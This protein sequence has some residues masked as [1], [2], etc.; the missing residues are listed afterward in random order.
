MGKRILYSETFSG[1]KPEYFY[2]DIYVTKSRW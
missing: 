1:M 2:K